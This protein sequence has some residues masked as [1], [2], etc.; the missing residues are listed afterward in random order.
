MKFNSTDVSALALAS[1]RAAIKLASLP[2]VLQ[3]GRREEAWAHAT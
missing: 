2:A 1:V 3:E